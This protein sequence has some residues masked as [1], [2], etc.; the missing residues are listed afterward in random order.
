M[1]TPKDQ[2]ISI[3]IADEPA[4]HERLTNVVRRRAEGLVSISV[5]SGEEAGLARVTVVLKT[6]R[7]EAEAFRRHVEKMIDV[8]EAVLAE[9]FA[10]AQLALM[11]VTVD[12]EAQSRAVEALARHGARLLRRDVGQLVAQVSD[13]P[14]RIEAAVAELSAIGPAT[15]MRTGLVAMVG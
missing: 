13:L 3:L 10:V 12:G 6:T 14:E 1:D 11:R 5:A 9:E 7:F 2:L 4:A 15:A 8:V